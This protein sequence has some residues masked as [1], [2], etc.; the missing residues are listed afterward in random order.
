VPA[1][2]VP[3]IVPA[4]MALALLAGACG[5]GPPP[6]AG[7]AAGPAEPAG[8]AEAGRDGSQGFMPT[9]AWDHPSIAVRRDG[10]VFV[11]SQAWSLE[12]DRLELREATSGAEPLVVHRSPS[13]VLRTALAV[14]GDEVL[15]AVWTENLGGRYALRTARVPPGDED[16][17]LGATGSPET[18]ARA[19]AAGW[20]MPALVA[21]DEGALLLLAM[22]VAAGGHAID[23]WGRREGGPWRGPVRVSDDRPGVDHWTPQAA[24]RAPGRFAVVW[25]AAVDGDFDVLLAEV[26]LAPDGTPRPEPARRVTDT[27]RREAH[28]SVAAVGERLYVAYDVGPER[29][30][31]E[32][33]HNALDQA[34]R[35]TRRIEIVAVQDGYVAPLEA[36]VLD[37]M[38]TAMRDDVELPTLAADGHGNLTLFFRGLPLPDALDEPLSPEFQDRAE[39]TRGGLGWRTSIWISYMTRL[40]G[41]RWW[42][43]RRGHVAIAG[44]QGRADA[45]VAVAQLPRGGLAFAVAGDGRT[46]DEARTRDDETVFDEGDWA[47]RPLTQAGLRIAPGRLAKAPPAP[48][49]AVGPARRL[50]PLR[51]APAPARP[52]PARVLDGTRHE[53]VLGDLH[54]HTDLSRCSSNWDGS[55]LD[56]YRYAFDAGRLDFMAITD[57][58]EH[59][60]PYDWWRSRATADAF[61]VPG[62]FV[63]F[64]AYERAD[65]LG[66]HR[67]VVASADSV[68]VIGHATSF[69]SRR[70]DGLA[71]RVPG[72][73]EQLPDGEVITIPHTPA[74]MVP[75]GTV[76]MDWSTFDPAFDRIVEVWQGYRGSS[77][78]AGA[79]RVIA[80]LEPGWFVRDALDHGLHFGLVASSDHQSSYGAFAGAWTTGRTRGEVFEALH[81]RRVFGST[82]PVSLWAEWGGVP[83]GGWGR[84]EPGVHALRVEADGF[85]MPITR[86]ELIHD[87]RRVASRLLEGTTTEQV[88]EVAVE[89]GTTS[90]AYVRLTLGSDEL[91]WTSPIRLGTGPVETPDG[92]TGAE[93][94][95]RSEDGWPPSGD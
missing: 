94:A 15:H 23:A 39:S 69:H 79:P 53:L 80:G 5:E 52:A 42:L 54:R 90:Y 51:P 14:D 58:F 2:P 44:S 89:E 45:R 25:D 85:G 95:E 91:A 47:F 19:P 66:G 17:A 93:V 7:D 4:I 67:N 55:M 40:E 26:T 32:G 48:P 49:P 68:P 62:R 37:G 64:R 46:R 9:E 83:M 75:G 38:T 20:Q 92:P 81:A 35:Q 60:T 77:E 57:H 31:L 59:M 56:A 33:S 50:A 72:L 1:I 87:G 10:G 3:A 18:I 11:L 76:R 30:G 43:G 34:L 71:R 8:Q 13:Q 63:A 24:A 41:G 82:V 74:G 70:D 21:D 84:V 88:F 78:A 16:L 28:A 36:D 12:G 73:F 65:Q 61:D 27:P 6:G 22:R 86:A 29:W